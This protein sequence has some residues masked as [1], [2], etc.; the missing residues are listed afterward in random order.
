MDASAQ[1]HRRTSFPPGSLPPV[2]VAVV[3]AGYLGRFHAEKYAALDGVELVGVVDV[4]TA[5]AAEVASLC[6]SRAFGRHLD[7]MGRV[8]AVSIVVPTPLHFAI[9]GDCLRNGIDVLIEKP[10]T[11]TLVEARE[12]IDIAEGEG[13]ILQVGHLERFNPAV[14]AVRERI[15]KPMFIESHRLSL[16]QGRSTDVSVV[17]DLMIHDIDIILNFVGAPVK[18]IH[19]SGAA[20]VSEHCDIANARIEFATGCVANITASRISTKNQRKVR[21]FQKNAYIAVDFAAR[22]I[23]HIQQTGHT[24]SAPIP[25][26]SVDQTRFPEGDALEDELRAFVDAVATRHEPEVT[27]A[28][29]YQALE[30]ALNVMEQIDD[31]TRRFGAL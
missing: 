16:F 24:G 30:I 25:G 11:T 7:L 3:G 18:A 1:A 2:R 17:L 8:D 28:M 6:R 27:G 9:A 20:V 13:L 29:G 23:T 14:V 5:K 31:A 26:M 10:M 22:E 15:H 4:D 19:A 21:L 12:L